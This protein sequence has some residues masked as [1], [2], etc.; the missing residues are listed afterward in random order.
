MCSRTEWRCS[1]S[2][3]IYILGYNSVPRDEAK[4]RV[5]LYMASKVMCFHM[6]SIWLNITQGTIPGLHSTFL[7]RLF[8]YL[9]IVFPHF[10]IIYVYILFMYGTHVILIKLKHF[11]CLQRVCQCT[12]EDMTGG[13][14]HWLQSSLDPLD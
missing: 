1:P 6:Y 5:D 10:I 3:W 4:L 8:F 13:R 14:R 11:Y 12:V 7:R 9:H 2:V